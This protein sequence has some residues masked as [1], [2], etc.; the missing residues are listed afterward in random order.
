MSDSVN[1][2]E[3]L[4]SATSVAAVGLAVPTAMSD[5][6]NAHGT[7]EPVYT[8]D[9]LNIRD[10]PTTSGGIIRT[11]D[12]NTG[13]RIEDGP[14]YNDGYRWWYFRVNGDSDDLG[15]TKGYA[16][17]DWTAHP[18]FA[19][20]AWG[21]ISSTYWDTRDNGTRY[22]RACD[23][24]NDYGTNIYT[25]RGGTVSYAGEAS[26]YGNVV[27]VDHSDGY[28]TRYAHLSSIGTYTGATVGDGEYIGDM[29]CSG[30]CS[31]TH[32][33]FE[34]RRDGDK[35][36]WPMV[37]DSRIWLKTAIPKNFPYISGTVYP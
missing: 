19:Y 32:L 12:Q 30:S 29:G 20:P 7:W 35:L 10:S 24:A 9:A 22:H 26:G 15:R 31:G 14:Y 21:R 8:T 36:N 23:I 1:R 28:Q 17:D 34:I 11:A 13:M 5:D 27:Y 4:R 6:A 37:K 16:A 33:H 25:A 2:R 3:F 18:N